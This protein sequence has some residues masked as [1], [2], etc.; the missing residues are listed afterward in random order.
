MGPGLSLFKK[1]FKIQCLAECLA[2]NSLKGMQT[3][4]VIAMNC[5]TAF[6]QDN[7]EWQQDLVLLKIKTKTKPQPTKQTN[8][9]H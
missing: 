4:S 7:Q 2:P 5:Q 9:T 1:Y 3:F 6:W 8:K